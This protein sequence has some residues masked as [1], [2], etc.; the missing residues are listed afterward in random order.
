MISICPSICLFTAS[1]F[2]IFSPCAGENFF[3]WFLLAAL[4]F[5]KELPDPNLLALARSSLSE[6]ATR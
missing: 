4:Y 1:Q 2:H 6:K 3:S 5:N